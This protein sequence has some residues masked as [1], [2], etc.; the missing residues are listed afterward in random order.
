MPKDHKRNTKPLKE[1]RK[2]IYDEKHNTLRNTLD[3]EHIRYAQKR[4]FD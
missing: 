3:G 1:A 4:Y 2:R